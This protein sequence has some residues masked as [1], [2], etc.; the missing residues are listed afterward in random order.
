MVI[1]S[2]ELEADV[3]AVEPI[4]QI[5]LVPLFGFQVDI[6]QL[7]GIGADVQPVAGQLVDGRSAEAFGD[8]ELYILTVRQ[9]VRSADAARPSAS[10]CC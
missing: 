3:L 10:R 2:F 9:L 1:E 7:E 5:D 8:I 4:G 6:A